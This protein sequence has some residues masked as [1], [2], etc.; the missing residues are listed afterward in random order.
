MTKKEKLKSS[1]LVK[2]VRPTQIVLDKEQVEAAFKFWEKA[3]LAALAGLCASRPA[4]TSDVVL[5]ADEIADRATE[6]VFGERYLM[7]LNA[8]ESIYE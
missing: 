2:R 1:K 7:Y 3:Y 4:S 8:K 6:V 5:H